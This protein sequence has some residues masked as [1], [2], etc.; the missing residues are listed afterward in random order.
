MSTNT[1]EELSME[2]TVDD[3]KNLLILLST[4]ESSGAIANKEDSAVL[5]NIR[6]KIKTFLDSIGESLGSSQ[7]T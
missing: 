6:A 3:L 4:I 7:N 2:L 5:S 1:S